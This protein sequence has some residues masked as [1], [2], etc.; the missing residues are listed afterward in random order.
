MGCKLGIRG[1]L[2]YAFK[3]IAYLIRI[4]VSGCIGQA[5]VAK[6]GIKIGADNAQH[7]LLADRPLIAAAKS[8]LHGKLYLLTG[9]PGLTGN[10]EDA[11]QSLIGGHA[12]VFHAMGFAGGNAHAKHIHAAGHAAFKAPFIQHQAR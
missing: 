12:C 7:A 4:G 6:A 1:K 5:D 11:F 8:G 2:P 3:K 10:I 9:L